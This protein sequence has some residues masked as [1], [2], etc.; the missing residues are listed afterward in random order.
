MFW[1]NMLFF[2]QEVQTLN[3]T[4][5]LLI[6][7]IL[8]MLSVMLFTKGLEL[9]SLGTNVDGSGIGVYF[10][11]LEINDRVSEKIIPV[12]SIGFFIASMVALLITLVSM[13]NISYRKLR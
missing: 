8:I 13:L 1:E 3:K 9:W 7:L 2:A 5:R 10:L 12:Y 4:L 6:S 11:G